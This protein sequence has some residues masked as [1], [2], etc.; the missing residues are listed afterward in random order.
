MSFTEH[1]VPPT[2]SFREFLSPEEWYKFSLNA[3]ENQSLQWL[4]DCKKQTDLEPEKPNNLRDLFY[5]IRD[6][7]I[8]QLREHEPVKPMM[9][10]LEIA[11]M[12]RLIDDKGDHQFSDTAVHEAIYLINALRASE[13]SRLNK[14]LVYGMDYR[15][16]IQA[17][18]IAP[19]LT[20]EEVQ[21]RTFLPISLEPMQRED[22]V[23]I[24]STNIPVEQL[25]DGSI[26]GTTKGAEPAMLRLQIMEQLWPIPNLD[27]I[28]NVLSFKKAEQ[29][30]DQQNILQTVLSAQ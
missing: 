27:S 22:D 17:A 4:I 2:A 7:I 23:Y 25:F 20:P 19:V 30:P 18:E 13:A 10:P 14:V 28:E 1:L 6:A 3:L 16:L 21:E 12:Q 29:N 15:G 11:L 9:S 24:G 5:G 8:G 26:R